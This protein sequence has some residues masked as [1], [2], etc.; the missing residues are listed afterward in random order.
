MAV[1]RK[2]G[3]KLKPPPTLKPAGFLARVRAEL[4]M[5]PL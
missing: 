4:V 1:G 5:Q 2:K 3:V